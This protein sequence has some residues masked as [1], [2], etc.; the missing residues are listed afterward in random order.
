MT[1]A[2]AAGR[3]HGSD[4]A[5]LSRSIK[6][7]GLLRRRHG[8]YVVK[9]ALTVASF[10][11]TWVMFGYLG[12][13]WWQLG[14]AALL[15]VVC[16]QL[17][18]LGHDAGHKQIFRGRRANDAMGFAHAGLVGLSYGW[19]IGK[20]N[21]HHANPNHE[22]DDPD[23]DIPVLAFTEHQGG[24]KR[25]LL[26]WMAKYQAFLFFPLLLLEGLNLHWASIQ[27][28]WRG[29][30]KQRHLEKALLAA[31]VGGYLAAVFLVLSPLTAIVFI[32]VHQGLWGV[33][34]GCS[35]APNHKGMPTTSDGHTWDFL[36]KQVLT[37]RN[38]HGGRWVDFTLGG[39]NYQI[40]HHL[41]PSMPRPNLRRAQPIVRD[42][43]AARGIS[44]SQCGLFHSYGQVLR[45]LHEVG[46][47]LRATPR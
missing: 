16:T 15:V 6:Q 7:A 8:Y 42:F 9:S 35:F 36:R 18:F 31:H 41:F 34:M 28:V 26:R 20:H 47:P 45:H 21:R 25:G 22:D 46:A 44:Y 29:E 2:P 17:S 10:A 11:G 12:D 33:Y 37:S 19:W 27:A 24:T 43:C 14:T 40:E 30:V 3:R 13:S 32:L 1:V 5:E 38:V 4:F 39:L 23:L